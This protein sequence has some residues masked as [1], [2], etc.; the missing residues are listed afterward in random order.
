MKEKKSSKLKAAIAIG[1]AVFAAASSHFFRNGLFCCW[2][3]WGD[4]EWRD[5]QDEEDEEDEQDEQRAREASDGEKEQE[6]VKEEGGRQG[7]RDGGRDLF[8]RKLCCWHR[9][10]LCTVLGGVLGGVSSLSLI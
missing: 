9:L 7:G 1:E 10:A 5:E 8:P 2:R 6:K 3:L 4:F